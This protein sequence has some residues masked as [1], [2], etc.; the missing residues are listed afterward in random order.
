MHVFSEA[1]RVYKFRDACKLES[2][3]LIFEELGNLMNQSHESCRDLYDCSCE[4]LDQ[5]VQICRKS[6]AFGS[7]LT[8][9]GWGGCVVSLIPKDNLE[10]F[11]KSVKEKYYDK[12]ER[13]KNL[14][15]ESAFSTKPSDGISIILP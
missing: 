10:S 11:L 5:L 15:T 9:A 12:N 4:E 13:L 3:A 2:A 6:G 14:F 8:G 1:Q 7:R